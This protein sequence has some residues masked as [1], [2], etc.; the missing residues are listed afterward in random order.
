MSLFKITKDLSGNITST[1]I[2][3]SADGDFG[4]VTRNKIGNNLPYYAFIENTLGKDGSTLHFYDE[5]YTEV[6]SNELSV[7]FFAYSGIGER[8]IFTDGEINDG[9]TLII[10]SSPEVEGTDVT[11]LS[12][13][14]VY[15]NSDFSQIAQ[16]PL[17]KIFGAIKRDISISLSYFNDFG[18]DTLPFL[19]DLASNGE[20]VGF[21]LRCSSE[22]LNFSNYDFGESGSICFGADGSYN[23]VDLKKIGDNRI[24]GTSFTPA[25]EGNY[26]K[27]DFLD[28]TGG[29]VA[30]MACAVDSN[31]EM[32][33]FNT[34]IT[35]WD[36]ELYVG[37][38]SNSLNYY[39]Y[40][41]F[42]WGN[43]FDFEP[44]IG[45]SGLLPLYFYLGYYDGSTPINQMN[46]PE[47]PGEIIVKVIELD[48]GNELQ[49]LEYFPSS[50][51]VV[52]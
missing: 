24:G 2:F 26:F 44:I 38:F 48:T 20:A 42:P 51:R 46:Y 37:D 19:F 47:L 4:Y 45:E 36:S 16:I 43:T 40:C 52:Y 31:D 35:T 23:E 13:A 7:D 11:G 14:Y 12:N 33:I 49:V 21:N 34:E 39:S 10:Q 50:S 1:E 28:Y 17:Y 15:K 27:I 6:K 29:K 32:V 25:L 41:K 18:P 9:H 5:N 3:T 22:L 30:I 8:I